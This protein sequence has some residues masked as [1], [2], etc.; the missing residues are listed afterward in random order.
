M[1]KGD[2]CA[3]AKQGLKPDYRLYPVETEILH[4]VSRL[5]EALLGR[6]RRARTAGL[7]ESEICRTYHVSPVA[8][9]GVS[10]MQSPE[11]MTPEFERRVRQ[12]AKLL[13]I[14]AIRAATE[15]GENEV[16]PE[17]VARVS[18]DVEARQIAA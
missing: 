7:T 3:L 8:L 15:Q 12:A 10:E 2:R 5:A 4:T 13:A 1:F 14:G 9:G 17:G 16:A 18:A 11:E 6:K